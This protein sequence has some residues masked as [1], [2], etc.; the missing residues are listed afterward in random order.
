MKVTIKGHIRHTKFSWEDTSRWS[1]RPA[2][3]D[4]DIPE[5]T[6]DTVTLRAHSFE[7]D[8][9]E[10][11][12]PIPQ[13][14]AALKR[15]MQDIQAKAHLEASKLEEDIQKLLAIGYDAHIIAQG[16]ELL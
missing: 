8:V 3:G 14:V 5:D 4:D 10:A 6:A 7:V 1:F 9:P 16:E 15:K 12:N 13:Q 2:W 11:F